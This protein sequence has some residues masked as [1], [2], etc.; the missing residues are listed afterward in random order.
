MA[1][2]GQGQRN[3][4]TSRGGDL[5]KNAPRNENI[6]V[7]HKEIEENVEVENDEDVGQEEEGLVGPGFLPVVQA[8]QT[9]ANPFIDITVPKVGRTVGRDYSRQGGAAVVRG[10]RLSGPRTSE[11]DSEREE[12]SFLGG[13][14]LVFEPRDPTSTLWLCTDTALAFSLLSTWHLQVATDRPCLEDQ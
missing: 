5:V 6:F 8:T 9:P 11:K 2:K 13:F 10:G 4:S 1:S 12:S 14:N 7:H 3:S